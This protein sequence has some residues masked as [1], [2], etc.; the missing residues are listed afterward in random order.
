VLAILGLQ[1][2]RW[3]HSAGLGGGALF[4]I[5]WYHGLRS[6]VVGR[7]AVIDAV[8]M[9]AALVWIRRG[10]DL[11]AGGP[12]LSSVKPQMPLL[13]I[14]FVLMWAIRSHRRRLA[15]SIVGSMVALYGLSLLVFPGW[16]IE[17]A[18]QIV[19]HSDIALGSPVS[20][21]FAGLGAGS[22]ADVGGD[23]HRTLVP[24][25]GMWRST[26]RTIPTSN[27]LPT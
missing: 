21:A 14:P 16:P 13:L 9:A 15:L 23:R 27:G 12:G 20:I 7:F 22:V 2:V 11:A 6:I 18:R 10:E 5:L 1:Q 19:A 26:G 24:V 17:W 25:L 8:L 3:R 4:S